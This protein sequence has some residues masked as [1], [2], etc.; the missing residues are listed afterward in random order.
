MKKYVWSHFAAR[1]VPPLET[2]LGNLHL[3]S[4]SQT[5]ESHRRAFASHPGICPPLKRKDI[6]IDSFLVWFS[7]TSIVVNPLLFSHRRR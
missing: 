2:T 5:T 6:Y 7:N 3:F 1:G 4:C